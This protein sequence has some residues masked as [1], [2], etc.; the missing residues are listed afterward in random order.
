MVK[1][2]V[3]RQHV[4]IRL[5]LDDMAR[6]VARETLTVLPDHGDQEFV[7]CRLAPEEDG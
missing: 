5:T 6:L 4:H 7:I 1:V 2:N 3:K